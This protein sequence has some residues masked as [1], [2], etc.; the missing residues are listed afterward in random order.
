MKK[1]I[2]ALTAAAAL[3]LAPTVFAQGVSNETP[4]Q[5]PKGTHNTPG[6][7]YYA[8]GQKMQRG[9]KNPNPESPGASG[10]APGHS[11]TGSGLKGDRDDQTKKSK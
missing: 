9:A 2:L 4:G 3:A 1:T 11:T 10:Y 5:Q 8:P 6:S 7:S